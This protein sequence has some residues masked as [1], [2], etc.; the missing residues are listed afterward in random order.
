MLLIPL[1]LIL[2]L[3]SS[4][5]HLAGILKDLREVRRQAVCKWSKSS[6]LLKTRPAVSDEET[7]R[8]LVQGEARGEM[9]D[10]VSTIV[11]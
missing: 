8:Y 3:H 4:I 2:G 6:R 10:I 11:Q 5:F 7:S 9:S 1:D